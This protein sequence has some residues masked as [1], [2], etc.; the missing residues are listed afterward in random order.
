MR[1]CL[2]AAQ[3]TCEVQL[4]SSKARNILTNAA[5]HVGFF[6]FAH[7]LVLW[8]KIAA[9]VL[10]LFPMCLF[11]SLRGDKESWIRSK[12]VEKKFIQKLPETGRNPVLRRSS[13]RRNRATT[14]IG[15]R[16]PL[17][18][19]P[20]RATLPRVTGKYRETGIRTDVWKKQWHLRVLITASWLLACC[21]VHHSLTPAGV[22]TE[23][24]NPQSWWSSTSW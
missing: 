11:L 17:K 23:T 13:G 24:H 8:E 2:T 9:R 14:Q 15:P 5:P 21:L 10:S 6:C 12:Y 4:R 7:C 20:N 22:S 1:C 16:P 3:A 18:P 19:K